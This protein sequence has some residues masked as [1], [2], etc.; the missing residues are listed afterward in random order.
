MK[1]QI[2]FSS[3]P[4]DTYI[5][6]ALVHKKIDTQGI[7]FEYTIA[8]VEELNQKALSATF[9]ITK[10]SY[11]AYAHCFQIYQI[12]DA[13]SAL[14]YANGPLF[15]CQKGKEQTIN[16]ESTIMLPGKYTTAHV[17]F[18]MAYPEYVNKK[19]A[20]F[21]EI[22]Q[23]I[24][25]GTADAGV[26][27]HE[28]RFTYAQ[29]GF[30]C[31]CDL[32]TAWEQQTNMP[33]PLGAIVIHR[34]LPEDIKQTVNILIRK[35]IEFA[36]VN[37]Y[38]SQ[39]FIDAN[40]QEMESDIKKQHINLFVNDFSIDLGLVGKQAISTL[41]AKAFEYKLIPELPRTIFLNSPQL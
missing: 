35:S 25:N 24:T 14:G 9:H 12:L 34:S 4:N 7:D 11:F 22:E 27:I 17:L 32:G 8:D 20:V 5:F 31:I 23:A 16:A 2:A 37:P 40:A 38:E 6:D 28:N 21:Y 30:S 19:F 18:C 33:I 3:C 10:I 36:R 13:G 41:Y 1:L 29:R 26:I 39:P 15:I